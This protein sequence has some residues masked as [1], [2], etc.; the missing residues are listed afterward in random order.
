MMRCNLTPTEPEGY[1][2]IDPRKSNPPKPFPLPAPRV[3]RNALIPGVDILGAVYRRSD[4]SAPCPVDPDVP[5]GMPVHPCYTA[6]TA[7]NKG[8]GWAYRQTNIYREGLFL[9]SFQN[10]AVMLYEPEGPFCVPVNHLVWTR[11][12][13][14][15]IS[16]IDFWDGY[17]AGA[18]KGYERDI[19]SKKSVNKIPSDYS[20]GFM[21]GYKDGYGRSD[22]TRLCEFEPYNECVRDLQLKRPSEWGLPPEA[23]VIPFEIIGHGRPEFVDRPMELKPGDIPKVRLF[24]KAVHY[25]LPPTTLTERRKWSKLFDRCENP[26]CSSG[27]SPHKGSGYCRNCYPKMRKFTEPEFRDRLN[28]NNRAFRARKKS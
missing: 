23:I 11:A 19:V 26:R 9:G 27:A 1:H 10:F 18:E 20:R 3:D 21:E 12:L 24:T 5:F 16:L 25:S 28:A 6:P 14:S 2:R 22:R 17:G 8:P 15:P 4:K 13:G 7:V